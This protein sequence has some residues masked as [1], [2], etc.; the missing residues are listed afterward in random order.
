VNAKTFEHYAVHLPVGLVIGIVE[1]IPGAA[2]RGEQELTR[3]VE[4]IEMQVRTAK[5]VGQFSA[6]RL[7]RMVADQLEQRLEQM[8]STAKPKPAAE[9]ADRSAGATDST[10]A[11]VAGSTGIPEN[12]EIPAAPERRTARARPA[13]ATTRGARQGDSAPNRSTAPASRATPTTSGDDLPIAG[14]DQLSAP[15]IVASL[16]GLSA[17]DLERIRRHETDGRHRR[18]VLHRISQLLDDDR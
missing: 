11:P 2:Q 14:Y 7:R 8:R 17:S 3:L 13:S 18:T 15:Q 10:T 4:R 9:T 6:P 1:A 12:P 16:A 5:V